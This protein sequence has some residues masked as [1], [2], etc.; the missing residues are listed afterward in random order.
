M[1]LGQ[2]NRHAYRYDP[3]LQLKSCF[4][5]DVAWHFGCQVTKAEQWFGENLRPIWNGLFSNLKRL[6]GGEQSGPPPY[7]AISRQMTMKLS[8][9]VL[10][11][12][13]FT[14]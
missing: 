4:G 6:G 9:N 11:V 7:L 12:A 2:Q 1:T 10:W 5:A 14:T 8:K 3:S 13:I